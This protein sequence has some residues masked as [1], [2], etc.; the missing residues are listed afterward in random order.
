MRA[1]GHVDRVRERVEVK[2]DVRAGGERHGEGE[3]SSRRSE[4]SSTSAR[5]W[6]CDARTLH[7]CR[8][9]LRS[10]S[11]TLRMKT[12]TTTSWSVWYLRASG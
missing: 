6:W 1:G 5:Q 2:D 7:S 12:L 8:S 3:L 11:L 4:V 10:S 9:T